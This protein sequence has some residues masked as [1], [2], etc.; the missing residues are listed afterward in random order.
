MIQDLITKGYRI[1]K[2]DFQINNRFM[3]LLH[4]IFG[5]EGVQLEENLIAIK[6]ARKSRI[7]NR[8]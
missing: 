6:D 7:Q 1:Y 5:Y 8:Q 3:Q 4:E 2:T